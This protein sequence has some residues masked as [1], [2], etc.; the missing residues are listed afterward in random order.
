MSNRKH[1][2]FFRIL[3]AIV[4]SLAV[5]VGLLYL[6]DWVLKQQLNT[7]AMRS[8]FYLVFAIAAVVLFLLMLFPANRPFQQFKTSLRWTLVVLAALGIWAGGTAWQLQN[9]LLYHPDDYDKAVEER[10][11]ANPEIQ[12]LTIPDANGLKY[13]A[14]LWPN[15][16]G[17]RGLVL[18]FGGNGEFAASSISGIAGAPASK[19]V[20]QGY[21][22]MAVDYPGY[23]LSEGKPGEESIHRMTLAAWDYVQGMQPKPEKVVLMSWS[24]GTGAS[25]RLASEKTP[26]GLILLAPFSSGPSLVADFTK[27]APFESWLSFLVRNKF[28]NERYAKETTVKPLIIGAK[29][30][31]MVPVRQAQQ[32]AEAYADKQYVEIEGG[33]DAPRFR[34]K[35]AV[36]MITGYLRL[37]LP[38]P[39]VAPQ[40]APVAVP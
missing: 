3:G 8:P 10:V 17:N 29:D 23:G 5:N 30:D 24:L 2:S 27:I 39:A 15:G 28:P 12:H 26:D 32:L 1:V 37:I 14:Y 13:S 35:D 36:E 16:E 6:V 34:S 4:F 25:T 31:R 19:Q 22:V 33:H 40:P 21:Q 11:A 7:T 9:D 18:Y 20:F 38:T